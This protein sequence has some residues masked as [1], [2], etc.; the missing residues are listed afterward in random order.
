MADLRVTA[1]VDGFNLYYGL[2]TRGWGH[3]YWID[4]YALIQQ[5]MRPGFTL[6]RVRYFTARIRRPDDKRARQSAFLDALHAVS[7]AEPIFGKFYRKEASCR[8][9]KHSW[10]TH[11]EKMTDSAI[12]ANLVADAFTN[13]F[14]AA[15]LVGGDTDIV[16]AIKMV[17]RHFPRKRLEAWFPPSR[18]NQEVADAC[19]D[20]QQISF[21]HLR[22]AVM[23][24]RVEVASGVFVERPE[25]WV[26]FDPK[27]PQ[28]PKL[29]AA[30][31]PRPGTSPEGGAGAFN[32]TSPSEPQP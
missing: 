16:P 8:S 5:L 15:F 31:H 10:E 4:P 32:G 27:T 23:P 21:D 30:V 22:A 19:D 2:R 1:Y 17:R 12:A 6:T 13:E 14:D 25:S 3:L 9:C 11:E 24:D 18:K 28:R 20:E 29:V 26:Q 7:S